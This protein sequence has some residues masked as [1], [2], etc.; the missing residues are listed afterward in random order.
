[1]LGVLSF[2]T[3]VGTLSTTHATDAAGCTA[4]YT[5]KDGD[6]LLDISHDQLGTVFAVQDIIHANQA[7]IGHNPDLIFAGDRLT[8][9]CEAARN[10]P[11]DWT[12]VPDAG[13]LHALLHEEDVQVLDIRSHDAVAN[14]F[15]PG[16]IHVPY[17][18]WSQVTADPGSPESEAALSDIV[19]LS[20][21]RLDQPIIVVN[22]KPTA[23]DLEQSAEVYRVLE[24]IGAD[25]LAI[26][27]DGYR[28]WVRDN[29]PVTASAALKDPYDIQVVF[30]P[31]HRSQNFDIFQGV[32]LALKKV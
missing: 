7:K 28:G 5:I 30:M 10:R 3:V 24:T 25:H 15:I 8:I 19:G 11:L 29:L 9:P 16:S 6:T 22:T 32:A 21:L 26:L 13:T 12:V 31:L 1:M 18:F 2:S 14:G 4:R 17:E 20:G 27:R 23:L